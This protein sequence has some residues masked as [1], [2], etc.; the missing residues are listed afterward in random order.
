MYP[1]S[2]NYGYS[3]VSIPS[4]IRQCTEHLGRLVFS[5]TVVVLKQYDMVLNSVVYCTARVFVSVYVYWSVIDLLLS[6]SPLWRGI[7]LVLTNKTTLKL[8]PN[9]A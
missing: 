8:S 1:T 5:V 6:V 9:S 4:A 7:S 2:N 3:K